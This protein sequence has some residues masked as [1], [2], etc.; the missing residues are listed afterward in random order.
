MWSLGSILIA[1]I[2]L[3]ACVAIVY[4]YCQ[5]AG[6]VIPPFVIRVFW[7]VVLACVAIFALRFLLGLVA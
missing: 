2:I 4:A 5:Y 3:V 6:I 7:I 1:V